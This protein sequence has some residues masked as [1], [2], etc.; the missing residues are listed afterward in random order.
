MDIGNSAEGGG[1]GGAGKD[2]AKKWYRD[3]ASPKARVL[4]DA[5]GNNMLRG[6]CCSVVGLGGVI[7]GCPLY[8]HVIGN[9]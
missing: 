7:S 2:E 9:V 5:D 8:C 6:G 1:V 4:H 3:D